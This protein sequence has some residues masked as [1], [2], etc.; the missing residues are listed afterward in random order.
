MVTAALAALGGA[1]SASAL[2]FTS[3]SAPV[4]IT[5]AQT[6]TSTLTTSAGSISC[7]KAAFSG[8]QAVTSS[9]SQKVS[10]AYSECT[11]LGVFGVALNMNG[12]EYV[13]KS[14]GTADIICPAGKAITFS[15]VGCVITIWPQTGVNVI[16]YST[17]G[18]G[19]TREVTLEPAITGMKYH[20]SA[21]C[22]GGTVNGTNATL[23]GGDV[24][25]TATSEATGKH[26]GIFTS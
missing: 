23:K 15:A 8:T 10:V 1:G 11:F 9:T 22:P 26:V 4:N 2:T 16:F 24:T 13:L 19:T 6:T 14:S 5:G 20:T 21:G 7:K 25:I 12:C 3:E 17:I 18:S